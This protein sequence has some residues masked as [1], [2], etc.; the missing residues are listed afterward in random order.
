VVL[1]KWYFDITA[2]DGSVAIAYWAEVRWSRWVRYGSALFRHP[3][4]GA[5]WRFG[6]PTEAGPAEGPTPLTWNAAELGCRIR[7]TPLL[8]P[9]EHRLLDTPPAAVTWRAVAPMA[10][11]EFRF[12]DGSTLAGPGYAEWVELRIPP[13]QLPIE[14]L[15]WGR[16][17]SPS[18]SLVWIDWEGEH[19]L[20][21]IL[22]DGVSVP[23]LAIGDS[24][25]RTDSGVLSLTDPL[26]LAHADVSVMLAPSVLKPVV[27]RL[28]GIWQTR[29]LSRGL[30]TGTDGTSVVGTAI[31]EVVR[32]RGSHV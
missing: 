12:S 19:P 8:P 17:L 24:T 22:R 21:L 23:P 13:W 32:R 16:F 11:A 18:T 20:R 9:S 31:H 7:L 27:A 1:R 29:W 3:S 10:D 25:V 4:R 14:A 2:P 5:A 26:P 15:R 28:S 6:V 30:F